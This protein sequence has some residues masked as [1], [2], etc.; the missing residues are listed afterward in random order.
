MTGAS[1]PITL[2]TGQWTDIPLE[3]LARDAARWGYDG[4]ELACSGTH[5]DVRRA[6]GEDRYLDDVRDR[7]HAH[8]LGCWAISNH[9]VGQAVCDPI[10]QR[11]RA[12][13][14][15]HVWG[16]G[17]PEGVRQRAAQ[18]MMATARVAAL[19]GVD[20]VVGFTGSAI[21][22][23]VAMFPPVSAAD[24]AAGYADFARRWTPILDVFAEVG[25]RFALEVHP[26]EIAYDYWTAARALEAVGEHPAFGFNWD[27]SHFLWQ[28]LDPTTFLW[29]FRDRIFHVHVKDSRLRL[30]GRS[31]RLGSH[32]P[33]ADPRRGVDFVSVGRGD[34]PWEACWRMLRAIGWHRPLSVEWEDA[35]MDRRHG[36]REAVTF[37]RALTF[38]PSDR[39]FDDAFSRRPSRAD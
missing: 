15:A 8:G 35:A 18:E 37:L 9:L 7:L 4:L 38:P 29:D 22:H 3:H 5:L 27:P 12:I 31:G 34:V 25:V 33:W 30:D 36:A 24:V 6:L 13:L 28:G 17:D 1:T 23:T 11:H 10:D 20:T 16:D 14:P 26:S 19:L 39:P 21:W 2:F 32:L